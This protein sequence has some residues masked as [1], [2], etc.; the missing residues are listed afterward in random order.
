MVENDENLVGVKDLAATHISKS[1]HR[2]G[3]VRVMHH[4]D[5]HIGK[6]HII[7]ICAYPSMAAQYLFRYCLSMHDNIPFG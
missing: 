3:S 7:C 5:V 4:N 2:Q 1:A 6:Y